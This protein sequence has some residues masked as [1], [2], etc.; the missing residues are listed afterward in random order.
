[1]Q[2]SS[3]PNNQSLH[4]NSTAS[5][6]SLVQ[7]PMSRDVKQ[8]LYFY[9]SFCIRNGSFGEFFFVKHSQRTL[10]SKLL[11]HATFKISEFA[12]CKAYP[13]KYTSSPKVTTLSDKNG[14]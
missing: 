10:G 11:T 12:D 1:M 13:L 14:P 9:Y 6:T 4:K 3:N 5:C 7:D 2:L 8:S